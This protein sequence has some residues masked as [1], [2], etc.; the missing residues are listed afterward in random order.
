[1]P[2]HSTQTSFTRVPKGGGGEEVASMVTRSVSSG[3]PIGLD[4]SCKPSANERHERSFGSVMSESGSQSVP[5]RY[6]YPPAEAAELLGCTRKHIYTL[7]NRGLLDSTLIGRCRR[8]P[9]TEIERLAGVAGDDLGG[10]DAA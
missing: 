2:S 10:D 3:K 4:A 9:R 8:I 6:A 5:W 7:I 1:M